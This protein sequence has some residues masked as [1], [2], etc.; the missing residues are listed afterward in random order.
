MISAAYSFGMT[1]GGIIVG[2]V[3]DILGGRRAVVIRIFTVILVG[4]LAV[5]AIYSDHLSNTAFIGM[6]FVMGTLV[7]GPNNII[8]SAVATDLASHPSVCGSSKSLGTVTGIINSTGSLVSSIG[9]L[10]IGP[11]Q[12]HYGWGSV[13]IYTFC[14]TGVG[15]LLM[16]TK[17]H[18][19][20]VSFQ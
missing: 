13:W 18:C 1:P 14:C 8:T 17:I 9:L 2:V 11:L 15:T 4:F 3:S 7:G 16:T 10:F 12:A 19:E 5:F 6:L 20:I